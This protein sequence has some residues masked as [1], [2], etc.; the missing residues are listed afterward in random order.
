MST[1]EP[2]MAGIREA[3]LNDDLKTVTAGLLAYTEK[4]ATHFHRELVLHAANLAR[5]TVEDRAGILS[6]E[7]IR[8]QRVRL[9][10]SLLD[11]LEEIESLSSVGTKPLHTV[12]MHTVSISYSWKNSDIADEIDRTLSALSVVLT[13]DVRDAPYKTDL[14]TFMQG[15]AGASRVILLISDCYLRSR[16]CLY[17]ALE[18]MDHGDFEDRALPV[19]LPDARIFDA[20]DAACY[21]HYW[22]NKLEEINAVIKHLPSMHDTDRLFHELNHYARIRSSIDSFIA[23]IARMNTLSFEAHRA[24]GY[25][26]LYH[27]LGVDQKP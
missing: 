27:M 17:E 2:N 18:F 5:L 25:R 6:R 9:R 11:I 19:V 26:T 20:T 1:G 16:N 7:A 22:D 8:I 3:L 10:A 13:R 23:H 12:P 21:L 24:S 15:I 14:P 4:R